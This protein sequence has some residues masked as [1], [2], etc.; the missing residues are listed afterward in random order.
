VLAAAASNGADER[1]WSGRGAHRAGRSAAT[2]NRRATPC[3]GARRRTAPWYGAS[4][5]RVREGNRWFG[6]PSGAR[7]A[8]PTWCTARRAPRGGGGDDFEAASARA[9]P[10]EGTASGGARADAEAA[11]Q[12]GRGAHLKRVSVPRFDRVFSQILKRSAQSGK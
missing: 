8:G 9:L 1:L 3:S 7:P 6:G 12:R 11:A 10:W 5:R 2:L 4:G